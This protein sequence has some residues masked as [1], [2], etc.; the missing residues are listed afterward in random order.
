MSTLD[1]EVALSKLGSEE[2]DVLVIGGGITGAGVALDA[3]S[4]G[5]KV[6]LVEKNDFASGTSSKSSKLIHGGIRY[7]QHGDY[8]LV[9]ESLVERQRLLDNAP[10]L[11]SP[12]PF[13]IPILRSKKS[14]YK[15]TRNVPKELLRSTIT[16]S[17]SKG[18][19]TALWI[20][21]LTGGWRI[22]KLHRRIQV[23]ELLSHIPTLDIAKITGAFIYYDAQADDARLVLEILTKAVLDYDVVIANYAEVVAFIK[24]A[25]ETSVATTSP[26][27][28]KGVKVRVT[29]TSSQQTPIHPETVAEEIE[30]KARIV[31]NA[32]GIWADELRSLDIGVH[33]RSITPAKGIHITVNHDTLPCDTAAVLS[34]K[35]DHRNIF[36]IPWQDHTYIGTTDTAYDGE[37]DN[38]RCCREDID[39][40]LQAVNYWLTKPVRAEDITGIWAGLRPLLTPNREKLSTRTADLSRR[41]QVSVSGSGVVTITGGK[42]TTYRKMAA[43]AVDTALKPAAYPASV[44]NVPINT[45]PI[46]TGPCI[47]KSLSLKP[48]ETP[49]ITHDQ[50]GSRDNPATRSKIIANLIAQDPTLSQPLVEGL[51]YICAEAVYAVRYEM[52]QTLDDVLS[53]RTRARL[54]NAYATAKSANKVATI[55]GH[56]L[57][58]TE[59][60]IKEE[61]EEFYEMIKEEILYSGLNWT[62]DKLD[63][64]E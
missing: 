53:R 27:L 55:V 41:H 29:P 1:R 63:Q 50:T 8:R 14:G 58:W 35:K 21:D 2:F 44:S 61:A 40:L 28:V 5:L 20:Y 64:K 6:A 18:I 26:E 42:L 57:G 25:S 34:V 46:N 56:E 9:H 31:I 11:V 43:D 38:P 47:T 22:G 23:E 51:P 7:L 54:R 52:A 24:D 45:G 19:A 16:K 62:D 33:P 10:D 12:L 17:I 37:L 13:I 59:Q 48:V 36:V 3:A 4:R 15:K 39:Y 30:V 60:R 49:K 32:T